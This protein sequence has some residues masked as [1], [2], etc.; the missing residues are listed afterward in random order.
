MIKAVMFDMDGTIVDTE[1][2]LVR[3]RKQAMKES[4]YTMTDEEACI[5]RSF[6][7]KLARAKAYELYG[8][9]FPYDKIRARRRE[10]MK[11]HIK[12]QGVE[13]KP[14]VKEVIEKIREKGYYVTLVT[15][16]EEKSALAYLEMLKIRDLF[17]KVVSVSMV[18]KGKPYPDVYSY[19]CDMIH[20]KPQECMA[21]EDAPN[22]VTSAWSAGCKVAMVPDLTPAGKDQKEKTEYILKDL[23]G[24]LAIL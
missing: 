21:V 15:A 19:A 7:H 4:G 1:N 17:D 16:T 20:V 10:L 12:T 3:Y 11:E 9:S 5:F 6:E 18:E 24:L 22:G 13:L 14:Y 2:Y 8:H 23:R